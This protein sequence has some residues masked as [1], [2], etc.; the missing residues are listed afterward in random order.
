VRGGSEEGSLGKIRQREHR[1]TR[2][3]ESEGGVGQ[4]LS[5]VSAHLV[6]GS[7]RAGQ[8]GGEPAVQVGGLPDRTLRGGHA[9]RIAHTRSAL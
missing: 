2:G 5:D 4:A 7:C 8:A 6:V 1:V 9:P 3:H